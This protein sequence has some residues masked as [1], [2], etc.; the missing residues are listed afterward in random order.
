[1]LSLFQDIRYGARMLR[2]NP[3]FA[4]AAII[5]LMLGIGGNAAIFTI[6]SALLLRP[7][8]YHDPQ[9]LVLLGTHRQG[10]TDR[11]GPFSLN[12]YD[13]LRERQSSF[14]SVAVFASDS[15][16]L[17]GRGEPQ[18]VPVARVS[19]NF[20]TVLGIKP[21]LGRT[22]ADG[23]GQ[24]SGKQVVMISDALWHNRF[25]GDSSVI[26]QL[27]TLD[28]SPYTIVGVL[29]SG[30]QFPFMGP[31]EIFSPR[32]FEITFMT[33]QHLRAGVG[34]LQGVARLQPES[35]LKSAASEMEI[36]NKQYNDQYPKAP[37]GGPAVSMVTGNLQ[38]LTVVNLRLL[39]IFLSVAVGVVLLIACANVASLLLSRALARRKE[40][41]V[42]SALGASRGA[43]IRQLLT[44]SVLLA[45]IGGLLGLGLG[46]AATKYLATIVSTTGQNSLSLGF[47]ITMDW[48]VLSFTLVIAILTGL[49]FGIF[50]ALQLS[51]TNI[52]QT[53]RDEGR[54]ATGSQ[55]HA[56]LKGLLVI[57]QVALS[58]ML[59]IAASLLLRSFSRLLRV[60]PGFDPRNMLTM[61]VSLPTVK[62]AKP[63]QQI[64]F[65]DE[66]LRKVSALPGVNSVAMSAALPLNPIRITPVLPEG[67][68]DVPLAQR[69]FIIIEAVSPGWFHTMRAP[70]KSGRDFT[71]VDNGE[72]PNVVIVNEA[73]AH[74]YWPNENPVGK[75]ITVGRQ[76]TPAEIIGLAAD[77]KNTGLAVDAQPQLYLPFRQLPWAN[78][79]V[80]VRTNL[81]PHAMISAV[82]G[83]ISAVDPDQPVTGVQSL[84]ELLDGS[85]AQPRSTMLL[86]TIFS[87]TALALVIVGLYGV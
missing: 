57:G 34:Y 82:R 12:R 58:L 3:G 32:Y 25:G 18:Q 28:S 49:G 86:L 39:L 51:R 63:E 74:R 33:P 53:L 37:D 64:A 9:Q 23:E 13:L 8:P 50:P 21:Q 56:E 55:R 31:A 30:V 19:P 16:N 22:F 76:T 54:G 60:D 45:L 35:S 2:K 72:A 52:N 87:A 73:L 66:M 70:L 44:E 68:S 40:I 36:F 78:M 65:F 41:A 10:D 62:Y 75:H 83:Q 27:I 20:F 42:R 11:V 38:E 79:N 71:G 15:L 84:D 43:I 24:P 77:L 85:R 26:D 69:P 14:S 1:M 4:L 29:P 59:L 47:P 48:R 5:T 7:L 81:E 61:K 17:T 80:L 6:T 67:Q 46:L